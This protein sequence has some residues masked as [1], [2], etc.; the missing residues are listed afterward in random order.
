MQGWL[1]PFRVACGT[2]TPAVYFSRT[3]GVIDFAG[4]G[5]VHM[6]GE[7]SWASL[8]HTMGFIDFA[9]SSNVSAGQVTPWAVFPQ[10]GRR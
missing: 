9:N 6:T 1:S 4:S 7:P 3:M 5:N 8:L 10:H 2:G